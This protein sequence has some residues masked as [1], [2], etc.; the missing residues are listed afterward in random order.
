MGKNTK[1][2]NQALT[3]SP[4]SDGSN[5]G[6]SGSNSAGLI[7][8]TKDKSTKLLQAV[9]KSPSGSPS[10]PGTTDSTADPSPTDSTMIRPK[11]DWIKGITNWIS[12]HTKRGGILFDNA[13]TL[14][15]GSKPLNATVANA[16]AI[17]ARFET[18]S[19]GQP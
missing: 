4:S 18:L 12:P 6:N 16:D 9:S 5:S 3:A 17:F 7:T 2:Q 19:L 10:T 15:Q 11:S 13:T 14:P 1:K 8:F